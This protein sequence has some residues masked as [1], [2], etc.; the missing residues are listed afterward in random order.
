MLDCKPISTPL[1]TKIQPSVAS[2]LLTNVTAYCA[3]V[4]SLHYIT[5]TRPHLA[6]AVNSVCQFMH[7]P[8]EY[9]MSVAKRIIRYLKTTLDHGL[10]ISASSSLYL[11]AY[12]DTDWAGCLNT[13]R[14]TF[15]GLIWSPGVL[16]NKPQSQ[17]LALKLN[18]G[19]CLPQLLKL[20][21]YL[22]IVTPQ[23]GSQCELNQ[24]IK[25]C[26]T[27][28]SQLKC[29]ANLH[30]RPNHSRCQTT[31]GMRESNAPSKHT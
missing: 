29:K 28:L 4:D 13:W 20:H 21:G 6:Y 3:L 9:H 8:M 16:R 30:D 2:P 10:L 7:S 12:S 15:L 26:T 5:L 17:N 14:S 25:S 11:K 18:K 24:S 23:F 27:I 22:F 1:P 19:Q 31:K